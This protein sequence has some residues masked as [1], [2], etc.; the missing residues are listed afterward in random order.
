MTAEPRFLPAGDA[1][2]VVE[3]GSTIDRALSDR[4]LAL[5]AVVGGLEGVLVTV[6]TFRSLLVQYDPL[7]TSAQALEADIRTKLEHRSQAGGPVRRWHL[8]ACYDDGFSPDLAEVAERTNHSV[9]DVIRLHTETEFRVYVVGFVPGYGFLGGLPQEL[10]LPRR[11]EPR[12]RVPA[13]SVGIA[14]NLTGVYPQESP[15]GWHLIGACPVRFFD[16]QA[17]R[18][19]LFMPG[20]KVR[21]ERVSAPE[22]ERLKEAVAKRAY[23]P[24][25]EEVAP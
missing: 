21:F 6:P 22:Y 9:A 4:V 11:A 7:R 14:L 16:A 19:S 18:P 13:G 8:P 23:T 5:S 2:L 20:D 12:V 17:E 1:A 3:F 24:P 10:Y 25:F 15:G